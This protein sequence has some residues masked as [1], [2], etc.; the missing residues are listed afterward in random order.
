LAA[1]TQNQALNA[2]V[3]LNRQVVAGELGWIGDFDSGH[4]MQLQKVQF[5]DLSRDSFTGGG[6]NDVSL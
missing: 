5:N 6:F 2:L 3:F 4:S 1:S